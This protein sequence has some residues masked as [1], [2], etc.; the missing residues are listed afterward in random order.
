MTVAAAPVQA[1]VSKV[2]DLPSLDFL[3]SADAPDVLDRCDVALAPFAVDRPAF[4]PS[5]SYAINQDSDGA[6]ALSS[7]GALVGLFPEVDSAVQHL[8]WLV[9]QESLGCV[10]DAVAL[11]AAGL[12][13]DNRALL[14]IGPSGSGK[15]TLA[16]E[17]L[18][19]GLQY[20]SDEAVLVSTVD[21]TVR[22][23]P[24][25][26]GLKERAHDADGI[27]RLRPEIDCLAEGAIGE[28]VYY[29]PLR[30]GAK[31]VEGP[32]QPA[33]LV[34]LCHGPAAL[35]EIPAA[36]AVPHLVEQV[37]ASQPSDV[38]FE[39]LVCLASKAKTFFL[40]S[41]DPATSAD[42]LLDLIGSRLIV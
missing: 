10:E 36:E 8:V 13:Y 37:F 35:E 40:Q 14:L 5:T 26:I 24:R 6:V 16:F 31:V 1:H 20:L 38:I 11:H 41:G 9:T 7:G 19:R 22:G 2:Y 25:S 27:V 29:S 17:L 34:L 39:T 18:R 23:F 4:H 15:S 33:A 32:V 12:A 28:T 3:L 42:I 21:A 30:L